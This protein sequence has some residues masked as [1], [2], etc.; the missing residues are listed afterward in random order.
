[1]DGESID[2]SGQ[3]TAS[4]A[5]VDQYSYW[6]GG[7]QQFIIARDS[8]GS[9]TIASINSL[10]PV[11]VPGSSTRAGTLLDQGAANGGASQQWTFTSA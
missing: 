6:G 1:M 11:E 9:C 8:A 10:D 3:S 5:K 2:I 4:G 7:N